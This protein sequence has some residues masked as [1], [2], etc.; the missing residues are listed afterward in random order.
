MEI[1]I[2]NEMGAITIPMVSDD[3]P[4]GKESKTEIRIVITGWTHD[5]Y[6]SISNN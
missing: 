2:I 3:F 6:I 5:L 4:E 1:E